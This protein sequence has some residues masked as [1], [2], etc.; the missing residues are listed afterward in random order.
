MSRREQVVHDE[1]TVSLPGRPTGTH[2]AGSSSVDS[3]AF[4]RSLVE[5]IG[6]WAGCCTAECAE[7]KACEPIR[8]P[9]DTFRPTRS[10][11]RVWK[12]NQM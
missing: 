5:E 7:C 1:P 11:R 3:E 10:Q 9:V 2:A 6:G 12:R 4:D 8:I